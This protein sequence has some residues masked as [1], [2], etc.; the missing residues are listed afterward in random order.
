MDFRWQHHYMSQHQHCPNANEL[1]LYFCQV[2]E[3]VKATFPKY[4]NQMKGLDWG[5]LYRLYKNVP[6][7]TDELEKEIMSLMHD[8]EIQNKKGIYYY[9][10]TK[11]EKYLN[12]RQF[13]DYIKQKV[14]D[15]QK[16]I[17]KKCG[18]HFGL[19]DMEADHITPWSKGGKTNSDNCQLLCMSCNRSKSDK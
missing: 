4:R 5:M 14:Y 13:P 1:W 8:D 7:N 9:V 17:C 10:L 2:I 15:E 6:Y 18:K 19:S 11:D 3:W 12:L 16:G